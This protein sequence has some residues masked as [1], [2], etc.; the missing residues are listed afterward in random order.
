MAGLTFIVNTNLTTGSLTV[1]ELKKTAIVVTVVAGQIP[2]LNGFVVLQTEVTYQKQQD[3]F[4]WQFGAAL[5]AIK[6]L[7][8]DFDRTR[9]LSQ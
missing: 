5:E 1:F 2:Q 6:L 7:D 8:H 4:A 3:I 9:S